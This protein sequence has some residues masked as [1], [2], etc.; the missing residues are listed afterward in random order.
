MFIYIYIYLFFYF[1][2]LGVGG[3]VSLSLSF[4][5]SFFYPGSTLLLQE[6]ESTGPGKEEP[7][8]LSFYLFQSAD[9]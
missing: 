4:I 6:K 1:L 8:S 9:L 2:W 3:G 5:F 7:F